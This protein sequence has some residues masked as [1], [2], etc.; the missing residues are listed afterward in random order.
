MV[1]KKRP[2][3]GRGLGALIGD[4]VSQV[5]EETAQHTEA[6]SIDAADKMDG[7]QTVAI[8]KIERGRYQ[9]RLHFDQDAL[10][11]LAE[12]IKQQGILQPLVLRKQGDNRYELIAGERRWRAAQL[13]GLDVVPAVV[14]EMDDE[15][16]AAVALIENIQREDLGPLEEAK[17]FKRLIDEFDLTH[18]QVADVVSRSRAMVTNLLRL[19]DLD[20]SVKEQLESNKIQMGHAR[21]IL[22]LPLYKQSAI[23]EQVELQG[24][25]VRQTEKLVSQTLNP[26]IK[27]NDNTKDP[28]ITRLEQELSEKVGAKVTIQH[29][30]TGKGKLV[31]NYTNNDE[32][33]GILNKIH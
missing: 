5:V 8:E 7:L 25:S 14:K 30:S 18:Q 10:N 19:L 3:L 33:Q 1:T 29:S 28:N 24:L 12:S 6:V 32:L 9:P 17:G 31:I 23:A 20:D 21:A 26:V 15:T 2:G 4:N 13:A 11:T 16:A 22:A 27:T